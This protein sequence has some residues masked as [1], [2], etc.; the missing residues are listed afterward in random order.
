MNSFCEALSQ[1]Q[2]VSLTLFDPKVVLIRRQ[3]THDLELVR[4][5]LLRLV[6][7][8]LGLLSYP[9]I[10]FVEVLNS[11]SQPF[12]FLLRCVNLLSDLVDH[13]L[14]R[15]AFVLFIYFLQKSANGVFLLLVVLHLALQR[16][17]VVLVLRV[18]VDDEARVLGSPSNC[19]VYAEVEVSLSLAPLFR[20]HRRRRQLMA[21]RDLSIPCPHFVSDSFLLVLSFP[22]RYPRRAELFIDQH[23][24]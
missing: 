4:H 21:A 17:L 19:W 1:V 22:V 5:C 2:V 8:F 23:F 16:V 18:A 3:I 12:S 24:F 20:W 15:P 10:R 9:R 14:W 11:L 6:F 7:L 13:D